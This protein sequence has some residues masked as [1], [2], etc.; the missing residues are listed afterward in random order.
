MKQKSV[1]K[2]KAEGTQEF[3]SKDKTKFTFNKA[4]VNKKEAKAQ[5]R[6]KYFDD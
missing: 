6:Q 2:V 3:F 1:N 5:M 4:P